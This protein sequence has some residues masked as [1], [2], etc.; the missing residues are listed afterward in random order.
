MK[1]KLSEAENYCWNHIQDHLTKIPNA[2]ISSLAKEAHVSVSTVNRTLKKMGY[3]GYSDFK[4]TVRNTK[5]ERRNNGFSKEV[6]QAIRK[7]EIEIT[8]TINQLSADDIEAAVKLIDKHERIL[9]FSAGLSSNVAREMREKL[10]LFGKMSAIHDDVD[11][12]KY[13]AGCVNRDFLIVVISLSGE[14]P[15]ILRAMRIAQGRGAKVLALVGARPSS[16]GSLADISINAYNSSLK[17]INFGLDVGSRLCLQVVN[18]ILLDT[19]AL[20]KDLAPIRD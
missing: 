18:R 14:T 1:H 15:E 9:I 2:S 11:Y 20:Y 17:N 12:M 10:Q 8:R 5:D 13:F 3:D 7:N 6:N 4:Q 16:I 19:Y